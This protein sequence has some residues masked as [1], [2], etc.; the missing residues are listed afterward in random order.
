MTT[1]KDRIREDR[2]FQIEMLKIQIKNDVLS[3]HRNLMLSL[4]FSTFIS[5]AIVFLGLGLTSNNLFYV[6]MAVLSLI[7]LWILTNSTE[8]YFRSKK[9]SK[10]VEEDLEKQFQPIRDKF[11]KTQDRNDQ[12]E[13]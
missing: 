12:K 2:E 6:L 5:V 8:Q 4:E 11:I 7:I 1:E 10:S 9:V 13:A 3:T